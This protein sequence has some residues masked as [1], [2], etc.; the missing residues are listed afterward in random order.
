MW[1]FRKKEPSF[2]DALAEMRNTLPPEKTTQELL[3][4]VEAPDEIYRIGEDV[5]SGLWWV[6]GWSKRIE[7]RGGYGYAPM[8]PKVISG[9]DML[10]EHLRSKE[11]AERWM[12]ARID[13]AAHRTAY[14]AQG[15]QLTVNP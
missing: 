14:D 10:V 9:Y 12:A 6:M 13:P 8:Y 5:K 4:E 15:Q 7:W 2:L 11:H 1:P 3:D